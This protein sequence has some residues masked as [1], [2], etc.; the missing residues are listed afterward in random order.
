MVRRAGIALSHVLLVRQPIQQFA[1]NA[2][3]ARSRTMRDLPMPASP[4]SSTTRPSPHFA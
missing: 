3:F 2:R 1:H 4:D